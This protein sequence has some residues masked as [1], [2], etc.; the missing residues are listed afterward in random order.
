MGN[1]KSLCKRYTN[2]SETDIEILEQVSVHLPCISELTGNDIF[3]DALTRNNIDAIVLAWAKPTG[4]S[5]YS[6]SVVGELAYHTNEPAVYH[7]L[8]TGELNRDVRGISQEGVPIAQTVAPILNRNQQ[9]I[10]VLIMERNIAKELQQEEKVEFLSYS[11]EKLSSTL[12][13]LSIAEKNFEEWLGNGIFVLNKK[14]EI[15]YANKNAAK[16]FKQLAGKEALGTKFFILFPNC[17]SMSEIFECLKKPLEIH[18]NGSFYRFQS[19][20]LISHGQLSGCAI[21]VQDLTDLKKKEQELN[22]QSIIIKEI[23]HRVKNNLQNIAAVLRLQMRRSESDAVKTEFLASINRIM[24]IALVHEVFAV[25]NWDITDLDEFCKRI[26]T[27]LIESSGVFS[28]KIHTKVEGTAIKVS[29]NQAIPLA[30]VINELITNSIKHG[31]CPSEGGQIIISVNEKN[32][33]IN[34]I[35]SDSGSKANKQSLR[36]PKKGLGM[37]IVESLV[38]DELEGFF[39]F[40]R[41]NG[42]TRAMIFFPKYPREVN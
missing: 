18:E 27:L 16:I 20:P 26:L 34:L 17:F 39:R 23:H 19:Y 3:I 13:F 9:I 8:K 1:F 42:I 15:T 36:I 41:K 28:E 38:Q 2:L 37:Q 33:M 14:G 22:T 5:L 25:Q 32:G 35:I 24:S 40:E 29:S 31:I 7:T 11:A 12:M 30:L 10:G 21:S 4:Y 6:T